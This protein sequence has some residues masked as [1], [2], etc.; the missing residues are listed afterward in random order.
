MLVAHMRSAPFL[1]GPEKNTLGLA[2]AVRPQIESVFFL[3]QER[4]KQAAFAEAIRDAGFDVVILKSNWPNVLGSIV[5]ISSLMRQRGVDVLCAHDYKS[6]LLGLP[7]AKSAG[8]PVVA[9]SR[10]WTGHD[11]RVKIYDSAD[12]MC[13]RAMDHVACVSEAQANRV[14]RAGVPTHKITVVP[15]AIDVTN[16]SSRGSEARAAIL[17]FFPER[18]RLIVGSIGRLSPEKGFGL[19]VESAR[20]IVRQE[21][22]V[23]FVHFGDGPLRGAIE[24]QINSLE[25]DAH[26]RLAG[27]REDVQSLLS[28]LDLLVLPSYTEGMPTVLIEAAAAGLAVVATAVGGTPEVVVD[29]HTGRLVPAGSVDELAATLLELLRD[30]QERHAMGARARAHALEQFTYE[31]SAERFRRVVDQCVKPRQGYATSSQTKSIEPVSHE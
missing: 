9:F 30:D 10:G 25:L 15:N 21:P 23:G 4:G 28:G 31:K 19:L 26:F 11:L 18:P 14:R 2:R 24:S 17:S 1:G 12:R 16:I 13:L 20:Q 22:G 7:A 8:K 27:F 5:E 3:F 29:R 6:D